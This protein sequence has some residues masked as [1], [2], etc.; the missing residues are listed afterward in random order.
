MSLHGPKTRHT[1]NFVNGRGCNASDISP[2]GTFDAESPYKMLY[3]GYQISPYVD[4]SLQNP[5]CPKDA[6]HQFLAIWARYNETIDNDINLTASFCETGYYKQAVNITVSSS[7]KSPI[8]GSM[9]PT[10]PRETLSETEFNTTA[11]EYLLGASVAADELDVSREHPYNHILQHHPR[12]RSKGLTW[13]MSPMVGFAIGTQN[14]SSLDAFRDETLLTEAFNASHKLVFSLAMQRILMNA[15]SDIVN[16]GQIH[17]TQHGIIVSRLFSAIVEGLLLLVA[18]FTV[19]L[20][21]HIHRAPSN[22]TS[23]PA[24]VGSIISICQNSTGLLDK[25]SGKGCLSEELLRDALEDERFHL[26]CGCQSRCGNTIIK[27]VNV[28]NEITRD[29]RFSMEPPEID[30]SAGHYSPVKPLALRRDIGG[31]VTLAMVAALVG[32]SYLKTEEQRTKGEEDDVPFEEIANRIEGLIRPDASFEVLQL[33]ENYIPTVFATLL[34]PFWV[35]VNRLLCVVQPFKDLWYGRKTAKGTIDA[36]YTSIPPQLVLWRA[37]KSGHLLLAALCVIGVLSNLLAV[38]LGGLFN[39]LPMFVD[40]AHTFEQATLPQMSSDTMNALETVMLFGSAFIYEDPALV[41]MYN[42]TKNTPLPAWTNSDYYFQ[43]F[44]PIV[45]NSVRG[46]TYTASTRGFGVDPRCVAAGT[47]NTKGRGPP[48]NET[49]ETTFEPIDG[50]AWPADYRGNLFN[51]RTRTGPAALELVETLDRTYGACGKP[52]MLGW[53]RSSQVEDTENGEMD[54][55]FVLCRPAFTT[56][57]FDVTVDAKG[58]VLDAVQTSDPEPRLDYFNSTS[59]TD[60]IISQL[61][62]L[63]FRNGGSWH[64]D[65]LSR[66]WMNYLLKIHPNGDPR[67]QDPNAPLPDNAA[68]VPPVEALYRQLFALVLSLNQDV[69]LTGPGP[70]VIQGALRRPE[71]RIFMD[72]TALVITLAVLALNILVAA[73][74]YCGS[75]EHFLPRMPTTV[76]SIIAFL[77]PSRAMREYTAPDAGVCDVDGNMA[78]GRSSGLRRDATFSFGRFVGDDG[79]AHVG[80]E[81]DPYVVPV[82]LSSLRK[83]ETGPGKG[84]LRRLLGHRRKDEGDTWL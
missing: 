43:P 11:F 68:L 10:G 30:L 6:F 19:L 16:E 71:I 58:L 80:I 35:L 21:W 23:D 59:H 57:M 65:T 47:Y 12:V 56:A 24:S 13:P 73:A 17:Y 72:R 4:Y 70:S 64:N 81:L 69:F 66:D 42:I 55:T 25:F 62:Q 7:T 41:V 34:E 22:L 79:R 61:N 82:K 60:Q 63:L 20:W 1:L 52:F 50:C 46:D 14:V 45:E 74:L 84:I 32:L 15:T 27:I 39:E 29:W 2:Y 33:L 67:L 31:F 53:G 48:L 76:G 54:S 51:Y 18:I 78:E 28:R 38:G 83:G 3:I 26:I 9:V 5:E 8:E 36:R 75:I 40:Y 77:A 49:I 37:A 44:S